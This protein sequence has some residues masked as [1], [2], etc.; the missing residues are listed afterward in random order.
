MYCLQRNVPKGTDSI[1]IQRFDRYSVVIH[2]LRPDYVR[3]TVCDSARLTSIYYTTQIVVTGVT[4][5]IHF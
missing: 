5:G 4:Q 3:R 1:N 2:T